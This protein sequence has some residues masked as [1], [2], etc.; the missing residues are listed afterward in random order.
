MWYFNTFNALFWPAETFFSIH[1]ARGLLP[2][3]RFEF[4]ELLRVILLQLHLPKLL[5]NFVSTFYKHSYVLEFVN[6]IVFDDA[7]VV[8]DVLVDFA[9]L[10]VDVAGVSVDV[11]RLAPFLCHAMCVFD[12]YEH[13]T[14]LQDSGITHPGVNTGTYN[15]TKIEIKSKTERERGRQ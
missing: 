13:A 3:N 8:V 9:V 5:V 1:A 15:M 11:G 4:L 6:L 12:Y 2:S 10:E 14:I 7:I